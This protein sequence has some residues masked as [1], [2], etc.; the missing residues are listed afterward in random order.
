MTSGGFIASCKRGTN[1]NYEDQLKA[2]SIA[3]FKRFKEIWNFNDFWKRGNTFDACLTFVAAVEEKWPD[4]PEV[5]SMSQSVRH[6]LEENLTYFNLF[7]PGSLWADDFG[8]WGLMALNGRKYLLK[9]D[10]VDLADK[11]LRLSTDLCWEYKKKT[12]YDHTSTAKP[13]P[14][15][16]RNGDANGDS[17]GVKNTVTNVLLFLLSSRIYRAALAENM[18]DK[19]SISI[20]LIANGYGSITGFNWTSMST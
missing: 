18:L 3:A 12:A 2:Q 14:H 17:R 19:K 7:D 5:R 9:M 13:I 10:E 8:W 15:G 20:W 1:S 4:D 11:Y 6:M 16:C